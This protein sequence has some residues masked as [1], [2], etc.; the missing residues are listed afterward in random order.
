MDALVDKMKDNINKM[1]SFMDSWKERPLYERKPRPMAPD[2]LANNHTASVE[3]RLEDIRNNGNE[4]HKLL[5]DTES[6]IK[7]DKKS[8]QWTNYVDYVNGLVIEG[9]TGGI[10][11]SMKFLALQ[12]S[13]EHQNQNPH[14]QPIFDIR[15]SLQDRKVQFDPSIESN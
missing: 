10:N 9:I 2:E 6:N 1:H 4:I 7:P 12:I 8:L 14:L 5:K 3:N 11:E 13:I 15:V